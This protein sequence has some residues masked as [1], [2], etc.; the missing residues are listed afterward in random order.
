MKFHR[1]GRKRLRHRAVGEL[2]LNFEAME[3]PSEPDL[4]LNLYTADPDTPA[5]DGLKLL[6]SWAATRT[7]GNTGNTGTRNAHDVR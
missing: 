1:S 7:A 6:A 3:L 4:R 5:A 2:D